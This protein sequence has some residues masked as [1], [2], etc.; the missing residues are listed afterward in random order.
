[1]KFKYG[2]VVTVKPGNEKWSSYVGCRGV[3]VQ[4]HPVDP[5]LKIGDGHLFVQWNSAITYDYASADLDYYKEQL[6]LF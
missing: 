3:V 6:T 1:M 4:Y 5:R 2:D